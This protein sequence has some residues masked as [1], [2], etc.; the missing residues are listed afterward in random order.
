MQEKAR[1]QRGG[2]IEK[3]GQT[4]R[5]QIK[6]KYLRYHPN[7]NVLCMWIKTDSTDGLKNTLS[8]NKQIKPKFVPFIKDVF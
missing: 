2:S 8:Q 1:K 5:R 7:L 3:V 6:S 4:E